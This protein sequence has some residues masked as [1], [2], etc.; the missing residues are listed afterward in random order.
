[1]P[2]GRECR[3]SGW[4]L[5]PP[6][7]A[8]GREGELELLK[9]QLG[10]AGPP[11]SLSDEELPLDPRLYQELCAGAFDE[12]GLVSNPKS[13][14]L[15]YTQ[16]PC[17]SQVAQKV[18]NSALGTPNPHRTS[19]KMHPRGPKFH[20]KSSKITAKCSK[21]CSRDAKSSQKIPQMPQILV[22]ALQIP[23]ELLQN[24]PVFTPG[25]SDFSKIAPSAPDSVLGTPNPPQNLL[26]M[27]PRDSKSHQACS[28]MPIIC[29]GNPKS[30][31]NGPKM[32]QILC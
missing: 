22:W 10:A 6:Q 14:P 31:Q 3:L 23:P 30:S 19:P 9:E 12:H 7:L 16:T 11:E 27:H 5:T 1:M 20:Q 21:F 24:D 29:P 18:P 17:A 28:K 15:E 4:V 25:T 13:N 26:K 32:P 8:R 2:H